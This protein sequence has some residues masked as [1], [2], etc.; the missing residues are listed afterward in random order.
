MLAVLNNLYRQIPLVY[1]ERSRLQIILLPQVR[2]GTKQ[3]QGPP[4]PMRE[5]HVIIKPR[6]K[7]R[8]AADHFDFRMLLVLPF[9]SCP[10]QQV[11]SL[12]FG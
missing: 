6:H 5:H 12:S 2:C 10:V 1:T 9:S 4:N 3:E 7:L 11:V 8:L